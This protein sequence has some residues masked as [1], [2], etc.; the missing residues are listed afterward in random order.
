LNVISGH[1]EA[2][3]RSL[4]GNDRA[5]RKLRIITAQINRIARTMRGILDFAN[6]KEP[7][8]T[9]VGLPA[10]LQHIFEFLE[11]RFREKGVRL[12]TALAPGHLKRIF[13]PF[14]TTRTVGEGTGLGLSISY[15]IVKEHGGWIEVESEP[16][17]GTRALVYLPVPGAVPGA[18]EPREDRQRA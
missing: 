17:R 2:L 5:E 9:R 13:D 6:P 11:E 4:A 10:V 18:G 16:G 8:L 12:E 1:A 3:E 7:N 14:F 15:G